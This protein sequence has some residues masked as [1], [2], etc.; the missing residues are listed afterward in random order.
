L[1]TITDLL[2]AEE[3]AHHSQTDYWNA[4]C[5]FRDKLR[6]RG[7][8]DW[9]LNL[10]ISGGDA[11]NG[12]RSLLFVL[13]PTLFVAACANQAKQSAQLPETVRNVSLVEAQERNM[14]DGL[15]AVGTVQ[16]AQTSMLASQMMGNI[17]WTRCGIVWSAYQSR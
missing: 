7:T 12:T 10:T 9:S 16:A 1:I 17:V 13:V 3:A 2:S 11:M 6:G 8:G 14:P 5:R 15:E 4:V